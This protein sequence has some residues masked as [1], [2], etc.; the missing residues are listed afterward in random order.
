LKVFVATLVVRILFGSPNIG[1][2]AQHRRI[3]VG[4]GFEIRPSSY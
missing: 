1:N 4:V 2:G 3:Y